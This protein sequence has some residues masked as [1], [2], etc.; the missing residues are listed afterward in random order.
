[1]FDVPG[2]VRTSKLSG[3]VEIPVEDYI[4]I[5]MA[6]RNGDKEEMAYYVQSKYLKRGASLSGDDVNM[7]TAV[8]N[9]FYIF[10][11][12]RAIEEGRNPLEGNASGM[13]DDDDDDDDDDDSYSYT[14]YFGEST[15]SSSGKKKMWILGGIVV[16]IILT[17]FI[18][19][20]S[21]E[22]DEKSSEEKMEEVKDN[23]ADVW[24]N[25]KSIGDNDE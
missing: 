13:S 21:I 2:D 15:E 6:E 12:D 19:G 11:I 1:M 23:A 9:P 25:I 3:P 8:G 20:L 24:D 17:F 5:R 7:T 16:A 22:P 14:G 4:R 10:D 18:V